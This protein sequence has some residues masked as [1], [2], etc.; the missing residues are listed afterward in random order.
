ME[1]G[2]RRNR[3][4]SLNQS[5]KDE[6]ERTSGWEEVSHDFKDFLRSGL[7]NQMEVCIHG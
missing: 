7:G 3:V 1:P 2:G 5:T 4:M 6:V